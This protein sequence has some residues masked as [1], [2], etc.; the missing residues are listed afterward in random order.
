MLFLPVVMVSFALQACKSGQFA[1]GNGSCVPCGV[2]SY[3]LGEHSTGCFSCMAGM[4]ASSQ[5]S[6]A[7]ERCQ[8]GSVSDRSGLS[9][10]TLCAVGAFQYSSGVS[11]CYACDAGLYQPVTGGTACLACAPGKAQAS[12]GSSVCLDCLRGSYAWSDGSTCCIE[13]GAGA[14]QPM[15][16]GTA[17]RACA[18]GSFQSAHGET[19]CATCAPGTFTSLP[20]ASECVACDAGAYQSSQG[21]SSCQACRAGTYLYDTRGTTCT[22]CPPG[23]YGPFEG[24]TLRLLC[25]P[26]QAGLYGAGPGLSSPG[27]A[28]LACAAGLYSTGVGQQSSADCRQCSLGTYATGGQSACSLCPS[29]GLHFCPDGAVLPL[30]CGSGLLC[31]GTHLDAEPGLLA[32]YNQ[33][34]TWAVP[35]PVGT[36][37]SQRIEGRKGLL[38][39]WP[40]QIHFVVLESGES[41]RVDWPSL[42]SSDYEGVAYWLEPQECQIGWFLLGDQCSAC[43]PGTYGL[44]AG[45][46]LAADVCKPCKTGTFSSAA[47]ASSCSLCQPGS[48]VPASGSSQCALCQPGTAQP[49]QGATA[50]DACHPGTF[51]GTDSAVEC[52]PCPAGTAQAHRAASSCSACNA[53]TE[54]SADGDTRCY[55][56]GVPPSWQALQC[57]P[58]PA[59]D[60]SRLWVAVRGEGK[61]DE[62]LPTLNSTRDAVHVVTL[63]PEA[64]CVHE[65]RV[66]GRTDMVGL[67]R[68]SALHAH[69][70]PPQQA[71]EVFAFNA[72]F[73]PEW[74]RQGHVFGVAHSGSPFGSSRIMIITDARERHLL[75]EAYCEGA[76]GVCI[77]STFCPVVDVMVR[78]CVRDSEGNVL[79]ENSVV[80]A[81]SVPRPCPPVPASS[82]MMSVSLTNAGRPYLPGDVLVVRLRVLNAPSNLLAFRMRARLHSALELLSM[83]RTA[84]PVRLER[85]D[86]GEL[87]LFG[88][89]SKLPASDVATLFLRVAQQQGTMGV[90][91]AL[92]FQVVDFMMSKGAWL[93]IPFLGEGFY[94]ATDGSLRVLLDYRRATSIRAVVRH[95]R[96]IHWRAVSNLASVW[97]THLAEVKAVWNTG[98]APEAVDA[99]SCWVL[100]PAVLEARGQACS[101]ILPISAGKGRIVV[102]FMQAKFAVT[103]LVERP[104]QVSVTLLPDATGTRARVRVKAMLLGAWIDAAPHVLAGQSAVV[105]G[106][107]IYCDPA[108]RLPIDFGSLLPSGIACPL[109]VS[110]S[111]D[112]RQPEQ[113]FLLSGRW[114]NTGAFLL[115]SS[116]LQS[117]AHLLLPAYQRGQDAVSLDSS[118]ARV[119]EHGLLRLVRSGRTPACVPLQTTQ[120][121]LVPVI[122][123]APATLRVNLAHSA[124]VVRHDPW[125]FVPSRTHILDASLCFS[126]GVCED[127]AGDPRLVITG[128]SPA[129]R[130]RV[131][132]DNLSVQ[133]DSE[134]G[135][136]YVFFSMTGISCVAGR[137][138]LHVFPDSVTTTILQCPACPAVVASEGDPLCA[139]FPDLFPCGVP[140]EAFVIKRILVDGALRHD[141]AGKSLQW[142]G[143]AA[144]SE[145]GSRIVGNASGEIKVTSTLAANAVSLSVVHRWASSVRLL[146]DDAPCPAVLDRLAAHDDPAALPPFAY[147]SGLRLGLMLTLANNNTE[148][149]IRRQPPSVVLDVNDSR[150]VANPSGLDLRIVGIGYAQAC[151]KFG[152]AWD[153][154]DLC[155]GVHAHGLAS[156]EWQGPRVLYQIHCSRVWEL[157]SA[158]LLA[159]LSDGS[160]AD[161]LAS[162]A[163]H[164]SG[165]L[166]L[167]NQTILGAR[168]HGAGEV[169]ALYGRRSVRIGVTALLDSRLFSDLLLNELPAIWNAPLGA[170]VR[171][172]ARP[173]PDFF[174]DR[175]ATV[176]RKSI[177]W[178]ASEAG[179]LRFENASMY[180]LSDCPYRLNVSAILRSCQGSEPVVVT[181][182]LQVNVVPSATGQI[183]FGRSEGLPFGPALL[184]EA[185]EIPV[186]IF[187][188]SPL[189]SYTV[190]VVL[191]AVHADSDCVQGDLPFSSCS[192]VQA[193]GGAARVLLSGSYAESQRVGRILLGV[194]RFTVELHATVRLQVFMQ[195]AHFH[196]QPA[197]DRVCHE[198]AIRLGPPP[199][200]HPSSLFPVANSV[201]SGEPR[202]L[203]TADSD[204]W[205]DEPLLFGVSQ[206]QVVLAAP[207][208]AM[209]FPTGFELSFLYLAHNGSSKVRVYDTDP[210]LRV[211]FDP[212]L[213]AF[214]PASGN[215]SARAGARGSTDIV[216]TYVQPGAALASNGKAQ[217]IQIVFAEGQQLILAPSE[218]RL[219]RLHCSASVFQQGHVSASIVLR[220]GG[221]VHPV[222]VQLSSPDSCTSLRFLPGMLVEG[223]AI[224]ACSVTGQGLG[225][226]S[227]IAVVVENTSV[228]ATSLTMDDPY[229][230]RGGRH[231][232]HPLRL[233][234][235]FEDGVYRPDIASFLPPVLR[236][237]DTTVRVSPDGLLVLLDNTLP[238][239]HSV[240]HADL[241]S[242]CSPQP[243]KHLALS[244]TL[245]VRL[246]P[247]LSLT[248]PADLRLS[249]DGHDRFNLTLQ[250]LAPVT[251]VVVELHTNAPVVTACTSGPACLAPWSRCE[252]ALNHPRPGSLVFAAAFAQEVDLSEAALIAVE[253]V[254]S[255]LHGVLE[256]ASSLGSSRVPVVAARLDGHE[257]ETRHRQ[258]PGLPIYDASSLARAFRA[259]YLQQA[260]MPRAEQMLRVI[261]GQEPVVLDSAVYSN[262]NELSVMVRVTDRYMQPVPSLQIEIAVAGGELLTNL[263]ANRS[264]LAD[265]VVDGWYVWQYT[266][267]LARDEHVSVSFRVLPASE[268][269]PA[270]ERTAVVGRPLY[271]CPWTA[272][273]RAVLRLD[274]ALPDGMQRPADLQ[275]FVACLACVVRRRVSLQGVNG[276]SIAVESFIRAEQVHRA[277]LDVMP[278]Y[279]RDDERRTPVVP[280]DGRLVRRIK[281]LYTNDSADDLLPCPVGM[282]YTPNG[283]YQRLPLHGLVGQDCYGMECA[284]GFVLT[285]HG[286][287]VPAS[288]PADLGM[289]CLIVIS[290]VCGF[291]F[292]VLCALYL[293][294]RHV[295]ADLRAREPDLASV[296]GTDIFTD[297]SFSIDNAPCDPLGDKDSFLKTS[298]MLDDYSST[299][300]D[301]DFSCIPIDPSEIDKHR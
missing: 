240:L 75:Y 152:A 252:C 259:G 203:S 78:V 139:E 172:G 229:H 77:V 15:G 165:V 157:R 176:L 100:T 284:A 20:G 270:G 96:L 236:V 14:V 156:L 41:R 136:A 179:V 42:I 207:G 250:S 277:L 79:A 60:E 189:L 184:G 91:D 213:L 186:Y 99:Y 126:D 142:T 11:T 114:D 83:N 295:V 58:C 301:D 191:E 268:W 264:M 247:V 153:F 289:I 220:H 8:A 7:C 219:K 123:P 115:Q 262:D 111:D 286:A 17:C 19:L 131:S 47:G 148:L 226:Q 256:V 85:T 37:C 238:G 52:A 166:Y 121:W 113:P 82:W 278:L 260:S 171:A 216:V 234:A 16:G 12:V 201:Y 70:Q 239:A 146:C 279:L 218:L 263:L 215:W 160:S 110:D 94:C 30:E 205:L 227:S 200:R 59:P 69:E 282:Y 112:Q 194:V 291:M 149:Q 109:Q 272:T 122:P 274:Y 24:A 72:T 180:L 190:H 162:S 2:G 223:V 105:R 21:S 276:F 300:L 87:E 9:A 98:G 235:L 228:M 46:L 102:Q 266:G 267:A 29:D 175:R 4:Y 168:T 135:L 10:C 151:L 199:E 63:N 28:C 265:H 273:H 124:L 117:Q 129:G 211:L 242:P 66:L 212:Y 210:R 221:G 254:V 140:L 1:H 288:V 292:C 93:T 158:G 134:D 84:V 187:A 169:H 118:R 34:A 257:N 159:V 154:P 287:C 89:V 195:H 104:R 45:G 127:V 44:H 214:D 204:A 54:Y 271:R 258:D 64:T 206:N 35:C 55:K 225:L 23:S 251:G 161:V 13:C 173:Q 40:A 241:P 133:A 62:C 174:S 108:R 27:D 3:A 90:V 36:L 197:V 130:L 245:V 249:F 283:T 18:T 253:P 61:E 280:D 196:R 39:P 181:R 231:Q 198:F 209:P 116:V 74:C 296:A 88:D 233:G 57:P 132:P 92:A 246:T 155:L 106:D 144:L 281:M 31:N 297:S 6:T 182:P 164:T 26:C 107:E 170:S 48:F 65:L 33:S 73:Y 76:W 56:C 143:P 86:G 248:Q 119:D 222:Q 5:G 145:D 138:S 25:A 269:L 293:G 192:I 49:A 177:R 32:F 290:S 299:L 244:A 95:P 224:G 261:T 137:F 53:S 285:D 101:A 150:V 22:E 38:P 120:R 243:L 167:R 147:R 51:A 232:V 298:Y 97:G 217:S 255:G 80:L 68:W 188:N 81:A 230:I 193:G 294:K 103:I 202:P 275:I 43:V 183:D 71:F 125:Q 67:H 163:V 185:A 50:C 178:H 141:A 208:T 237:T 128:V